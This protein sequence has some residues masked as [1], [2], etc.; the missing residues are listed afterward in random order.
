MSLHK[1]SKIRRWIVRTLL[2]I[3]LL[4]IATLITVR[5]AGWM[6]MRKT[7]KEIHAF[8]SPSSVH[9]SI[10]TLL[11]RGR[12]IV[13]LKTS[14][15]EKKDGALI[16]VHG[17][18]GSMDAFLEYMG[19]TN[20]LR[21]VDL[22]TYDRPGFG[23]SEFG[24]SEPSLSGQAD[25]LYALMKAL[26]YKKYWL[27]GHSYGAPVLLQTTMRHPEMVAGFCLIAGAALDNR[28]RSCKRPI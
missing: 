19:D 26:G 24:H 12:N 25:I 9:D 11:L 20:L 28:R 14:L 13:Y 6:R 21:H 18:P 7:D 10:D 15:G 22:I 23:D 16:L 4:P 27:A 8:L 1:K 5:Y 17:S 3:V 2:L